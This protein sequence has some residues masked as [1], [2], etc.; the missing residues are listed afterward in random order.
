MEEKEEKQRP[1]TEEHPEDGAY[2]MAPEIPPPRKGM[3]V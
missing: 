1:P 2:L 3:T